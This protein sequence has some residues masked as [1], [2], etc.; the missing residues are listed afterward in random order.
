M[1]TRQRML[2]AA[3]RLFAERGFYG[4]SMDQIA[5]ELDLTKQAL[6]HHFGTKEKLYG[7]VLVAISERLMTEAIQ[8]TE[9]ESAS[10]FAD[11]VSRIYLRTLQHREDTLLLMRELLDN[12]RRAAQAGTWYLK[13]FL[14]GL[15]DLLRRDPNWQEE[16]E[17]SIFTHVYQVLGAINYFAVSTATLENMYSVEHVEAMQECFPERLRKLAMAGVDT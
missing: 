11:A 13:P 17:G 3:L 16:D 2:A 9:V 4:A 12:R 5:R 8:P 7:A 14:D 1:E 10:A 15:A 6:I